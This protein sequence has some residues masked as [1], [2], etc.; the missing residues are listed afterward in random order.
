MKLGEADK[1]TRDW[2]KLETND[3]ACEVPVQVI[4]WCWTASMLNF[5]VAAI[6]FS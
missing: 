4:V 1:I 2:R 5:Q 3:L 6:I